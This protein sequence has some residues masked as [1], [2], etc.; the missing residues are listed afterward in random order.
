MI[1]T[2]ALVIGAGPCGL[3]AVFELGLL[4][5]RTEVV[6]SLDQPGGQCAMLYPEKPIYD[7]PAVPCVSG[8][9]LVERL[10]EQIA[11]FS[12]SLRLSEEVRT[13]ERQENGRF[14]AVTSE[15]T[16]FDAGTILVAGGLGSFQPRP[17]RARGADALEGHSLFY[18]VRD[19]QRFDG[20]RVAILGGGDSALD[21][22]VDLHAIAESVSLVHRREE[23]RAAPSTL[24]RF[25]DIVASDPE[26]ARILVGKV[27]NLVTEGT[28]VSSFDVVPFGEGE[29][30]TVPCDVL[31]VFY[32]LKPNLGPIGDWGLAL[33]SRNVVV[34]P[35]SMATNIP[36]IFAIGDVSTYTNKKKLILTGFHEGAVAAYSIQKHLYPDM[37]QSVQYTTTSSALQERLGVREE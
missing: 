17:L 24:A 31:L 4:G 11:P 30:Q 26:H 6:E 3:F 10:M 14:H 2:E 36:G 33:E 18:A 16:E 19:R 7:I 15:G 35:V 13:V 1:E 12:P 23:F 27:D 21:W 9:A 20:K 28:S 25:R 5:I 34:D 29:T 22:A 8:E 32:G 37:K